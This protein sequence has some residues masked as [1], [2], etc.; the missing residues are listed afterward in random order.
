MP[1]SKS[2][3]AANDRWDSANMTKLT[4][5]VRKDYADRVRSLC[6]SRGESVNGVIKAALD[7][8]LEDNTP[9]TF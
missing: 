5:K 2:K 1:V 3:R 8:Y 7:K 6:A 9:I 4:C